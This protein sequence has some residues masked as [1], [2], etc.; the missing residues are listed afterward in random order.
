MVDLFFSGICLDPTKVKQ[1]KNKGINI[2][3]YFFFQNTSLCGTCC[4]LFLIIVR[5]IIVYFKYASHNHWYG[6]NRSNLL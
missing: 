4:Q 2:G 1:R 3:T 6:K 5:S